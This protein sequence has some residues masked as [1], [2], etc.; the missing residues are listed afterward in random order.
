MRV[1]V[2][3]S[4]TWNGDY[5]Q[6]LAALRELPAD[7]EVVHGDRPYDGIVAE[8]AKVAG[9]PALRV[10][11]P[12]P[13]EYG[14]RL[15]RSRVGALLETQV[16]ALLILGEMPANAGKAP[17]EVRYLLSRWPAPLPRVVLAPVDEGGEAARILLARYETW[18]LTRPKLR[19]RAITEAE[20]KGVA[21]TGAPLA[22]EAT[23]LEQV[24]RFGGP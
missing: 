23:V 21:L 24:H 15:Y 10:P 12:N 16:N 4:R 3:A 9:F 13:N 22:N 2:F 11:T 7:T 5:Y 14:A 20:L 19:V 8:A 1:L 18:D 6:L 17:Y